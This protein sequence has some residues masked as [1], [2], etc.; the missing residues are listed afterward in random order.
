MDGWVESWKD[1][2]L[3][4]GRILLQNKRKRTIKPYLPDS[5]KQEKAGYSRSAKWKSP[6]PGFQGKQ[7]RVA[8]F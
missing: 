6:K 3:M 4:D 7:R 8:D 5:V 1:G 2:Q